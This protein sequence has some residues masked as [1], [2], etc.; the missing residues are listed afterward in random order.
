[1]SK[2]AIVASTVKDFIGG[3]TAS[4]VLLPRNIAFGLLI[5]SPLGPEYVSVG[6]A[7]GIMSLLVSNIF[8]AGVGSVPIMC[9]S[10]FSLSALMMMSMNA[11]FMDALPQMGYQEPEP[12]II[13]LTFATAFLA[14][15]FQM[16][17][18]VLKLGNLAKFIP[19]PVLNGL[20]NGTGV[21]IVISQ[22]MIVTGGPIGAELDPRIA[23]LAGIAV[24]TIAAS[25]IGPRLIPS[26]PS[27]FFG[28]I[29]GTILFHSV[30]YSFFK[31]GLGDVIGQLPTGLSSGDGYQ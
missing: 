11:Y 19:Y 2:S 15:F 3:I 10:T 21:A 18:G 16:C 4:V 24:I 8:A 26:I 1:L 30:E 6:L 27:V 14:G 31:S 17:F 5:F 12:L 7:A 9:L 25:I 28:I 22:V 13:L 23:R 29:V 20:L